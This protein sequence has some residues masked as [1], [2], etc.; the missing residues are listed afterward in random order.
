MF[1][2]LVNYWPTNGA[3]ERHLILSQVSSV[4]ISG[5][6]K[7]LNKKPL[8]WIPNTLLNRVEQV[9]SQNLAMFGRALKSHSLPLVGAT[10]QLFARSVAM[11]PRVNPTK[12]TSFQAIE[13]PLNVDPNESTRFSPNRAREVN[14]SSL[15]VHNMNFAKS[16]SVEGSSID[17]TSSVDPHVA[18]YDCNNAVS[19]NSSMQTNVS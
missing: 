19:L 8:S 14:A 2:L 10:T 12:Y 3:C 11:K 18:T 9:K 15:L 7:N 1:T 16:L 17:V 5:F 13:L 4:I 6:I